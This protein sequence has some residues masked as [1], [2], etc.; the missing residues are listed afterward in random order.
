MHTHS[1]TRSH[2]QSQRVVPP[3]TD[4]HL[5]WEKAPHTHTH[6]HM[7][8]YIAVPLPHTITNADL[9][10]PNLGAITS[11]TGSPWVIESLTA[12]PRPARLAY[13][14]TLGSW[15]PVAPRIK[16]AI[17]VQAIQDQAAPPVAMV[18]A[19]D[20]GGG[21]EGRQVILGPLI[22]PPSPSIPCC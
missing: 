18:F 6:T 12:P 10:S 16:A 1:V 21:E 14:D 15:L 2:V 5:I 13:V 22:P 20:R 17:R 3:V 8:T 19:P 11:H 7:L 4:S 9:H